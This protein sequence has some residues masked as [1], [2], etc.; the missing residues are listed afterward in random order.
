MKM[1]LPLAAAATL[2]AVPAAALTLPAETEFLPGPDS[3]AFAGLDFDATSGS[4]GTDARP[5]AEF[6][7]FDATLGTLTSVE[8]TLEGFIQGEVFGQSTNVS[9]V[10][11]FSF[12]NA[13]LALELDTGTDLATVL[14]QIQQNFTLAASD[15]TTPVT[16]TSA[17]LT[18]SAQTV[19]TIT[20]PGLLAAFIGTGTIDLFL[21]GQ[22]LAGFGGPSNTS[23]GGQNTAGRAVATIQYEFDEQTVIPLPAP[24][25]LLISGIAGLGFMSYR[26]KA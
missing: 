8:I 15:G 21:T 13:T 6:D 23:G 24:A 22:G 10:D 26:R 9:E 17:T 2:L 11:V 7:Q 14:P 25:L 18:S 12:A 4:G 16:Q 3:S 19:V 1:L 5:T 20:D